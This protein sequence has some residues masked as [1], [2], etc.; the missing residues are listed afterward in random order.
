MSNVQHIQGKEDFESDVI[1]SKVPVLVDFWAEWCGPCKMLT[2]TIE[3][4]ADLFN[5]TDNDKVKVVKVNTDNLE[6]SNTAS[7][8][9]IR[10][11]PTVMIFKNGKTVWD[12][13]VWLKNID[14]YKKVLYKVLE[15]GNY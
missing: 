12:P 6:N 4:L 7:E 9:G 1:W 2:P 15:E 5:G 14:H 10:G 11:I 13:I 3:A 8:F